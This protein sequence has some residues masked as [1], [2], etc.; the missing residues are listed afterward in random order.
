[1]S[2]IPLLLSL[3]FALVPIQSRFA[4][5]GSVR[6]PGGQ[7]VGSIRVTLLGENYQNL[8]TRFADSSGRFQFRNLGQGIYTIR[9]EP[10]GTPYEEETQ[11]IELQSLSPRRSTTEE[12]FMVDFRLRRKGGNVAQVAPGVVFV[13]EVPALAREEYERGRSS[14]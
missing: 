1:M 11:T 4:I 6:D 14:L 12:P 9:I 2:V 5:L 13:Q 7:P 10:A 8:G 3:V